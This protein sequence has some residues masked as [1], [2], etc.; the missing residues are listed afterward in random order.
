MEI[1]A[2]G[3]S[4]GSKVTASPC[5]TVLIVGGLCSDGDFIDLSL[6]PPQK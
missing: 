1:W 4:W 5:R 6:M 2:A 3:V